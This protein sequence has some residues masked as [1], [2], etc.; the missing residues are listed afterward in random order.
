M[1]RRHHHV[2]RALPGELDN[3]FSKIGLK[4]IDTRALK[5]LV[6]MRLLTRHTLALGHQLDP[7]CAGKVSNILIGISGSFG[8]IN[9][10]TS[11]FGIRNEL[12]KILLAMRGH[13]ILAVGYLLAESLEIILTEG[14][15]YPLTVR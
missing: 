14:L 2:T 6:E 7:F 10:R 9:F 3:P 1:D 4:G 12:F 5:G 13:F 15:Y 8:Q 11:R